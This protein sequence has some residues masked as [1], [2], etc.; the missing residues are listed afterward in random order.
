MGIHGILVPQFL[1]E[2]SLAEYFSSSFF[3]KQTCNVLLVFKRIATQHL[4]LAVEESKKD[5]TF[6]VE[7]SSRESRPKKMRVFHALGMFCL[8]ENLEPHAKQH[9]YTAFRL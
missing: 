8:H 3:S 2:S 7:G 6:F 9:W 5:S 1:S 4:K